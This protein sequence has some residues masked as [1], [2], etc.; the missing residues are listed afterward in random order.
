MMSWWLWKKALSAKGLGVEL[1]EMQLA[2]VVDAGK[3][4]KDAETVRRKGVTRVREA[5]RE[6]IAGK[7]REDAADKASQGVSHKGAV[8]KDVARLTVGKQHGVVARALVAVK[9]QEEA[10]IASR[11]GS[12]GAS[13]ERQAERRSKARTFA[14]RAAD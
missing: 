8:R 5:A 10:A 2:D 11:A 6:L 1:Q 9:L 13:V 7:A 3:Q 14:V 12:S 4:S